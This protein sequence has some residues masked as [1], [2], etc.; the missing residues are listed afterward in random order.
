MKSLG[1][2][3]ITA[4]DIGTTKICVLIAQQLDDEHF[5]IVG[6]G[7]KRLHWALPGRRC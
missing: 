4:I 1:T 7:K 6:I 2:K 3:T 5:E